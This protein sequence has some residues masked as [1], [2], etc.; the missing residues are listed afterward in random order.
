MLGHLSVLHFMA[1]W[2]SIVHEFCDL[3]IHSPVHRHLCFYLWVIVLSPTHKHTPN[4]L[5]LIVCLSCWKILL[6]LYLNRAFY[7]RWKQRRIRKRAGP[8]TGIRINEKSH[9]RGTGSMGQA[10]EGMRRTLLFWPE[11]SAEVSQRDWCSLKVT[12][13]SSLGCFNWHRKQPPSGFLQCKYFS[14]VYHKIILNPK[15]LW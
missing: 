4:L 1:A 7:E 9:C 15:F 13:Y 10:G 2:Y 11:G 12:Y 3:F 5:F 8:R 14:K 6:V